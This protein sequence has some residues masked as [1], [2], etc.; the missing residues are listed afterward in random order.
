M[1][2][3]STVVPLLLVYLVALAFAGSCAGDSADDRADD[4]SVGVDVT[5]EAVGLGDAPLEQ[6]GLAE[7]GA[8]PAAPQAA[9]GAFTAL[10]YNVAG[11]PEGLSGSHP[12][13]N[14]PLISPH[15]NGYELVAVQEDFWYHPALASEAEHAY[16]SEPM[17]EEP[18]AADM[19]DGLNRFSAFPFQGH[20]RVQWVTCSNDG[21]ADCLT[22]KGF[23]VAR[24]ELAPGAF[25]DLYNLHADASSSEADM[26]AR[27][28]QYDQLFAAIE[29]RSGDG[30][31]MIMGDTNLK[32]K[33]PV[34]AVILEELFERFDDACGALACG[35]E[36][37][38]R[39][40]L[41]SGPGLTLTPVSWEHP[42]AFVDGEGQK[43]SDHLP[44]AVGVDWSFTP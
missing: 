6:D 10:T 21:G 22:P 42:P 8:G 37:I 32:T 43:L 4:V 24:H 14:S 39:I 13:T 9:S 26:E 29:A 27:R 44:V 3:S 33:R 20:E 15:L 5:G 16:Q 11:L 31:V 30:A 28:Q 34:D 38:D 7:E 18:K 41:R 19:G 1:S 40:L 12:E 23:S 35:S 2:R 25:V 36:S 17:W